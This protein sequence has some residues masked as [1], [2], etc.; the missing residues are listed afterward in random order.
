MGAGETEAALGEG[1]TRYAAYVAAQGVEARFV[2]QASTFFGP[3]QHYLNDY[4]V[5][6]DDHLTPNERA[7]KAAIQSFAEEG[8]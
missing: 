8:A 1:V 7:S 4:T 3:D 5:D 2:K 6:D